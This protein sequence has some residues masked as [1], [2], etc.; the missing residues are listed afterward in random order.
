MALLASSAARIL[1]HETRQ[2]HTVFLFLGAFPRACRRHARSGVEAV[3]S[4][5]ASV[6]TMPPEGANVEGSAGA[7][8]PKVGEQ[9]GL[10]SSRV[11]VR[12]AGAAVGR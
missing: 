1:G 9:L 6:S 11:S 5:V 7:N 4:Q 10:V 12:S 2:V 8:R 3:G